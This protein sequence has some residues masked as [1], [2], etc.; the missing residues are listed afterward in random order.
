MY[1]FVD[2]WYL[3]TFYV[4]IFLMRTVLELFLLTSTPEGFHV[5]TRNLDITQET[6]D[7]DLVADEYLKF[8]FQDSQLVID[9]DRYL[10]HSTSWRYDAPKTIVLTYV[11]YA[12]SFSFKHLDPY[13]LRIADISIAST[14]NPKKPRP[15][16]ITRNSVVSH[17]LRHLAFLIATD[18]EGIY[19]RVISEDT[20]RLFFQLDQLLAGRV[21]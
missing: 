20:K 9:S 5:V 16:V 14:T 3:S 7:P 2:Y 10:L 1:S 11:A 4:I 8:L 17:A 21:G 18:T 15:M 19:R 13:L 12:D 6:R